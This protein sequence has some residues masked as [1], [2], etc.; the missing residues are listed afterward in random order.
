M[1]RRRFAFSALLGLLLVVPM[2]TTGV[3]AQASPCPPG[4]P[5]GRPPGQPPGEAP[6]QPADRPP[7]YPPSQCQLQLS[8]STVAAGGTLRA[9]GSG[10]NPNSSVNIQ[11]SPGGQVLA[12]ATADGNGQFARDITIPTDVA[13]GRYTVAATGYRNAAPYQLTADLTVTSESAGAAAE[14]SRSGGATLPRTGAFI[15]GLAAIGAALTGAGTVAVLA[16]RR[17]R[18]GQTA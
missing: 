1:Q 12:T 9:S 14:Q 2:L 6:G 10:Y 13:A 4:Q 7:Q 3:A 16:A 11:L 8:R 17:R 5:G 15:A 18:T